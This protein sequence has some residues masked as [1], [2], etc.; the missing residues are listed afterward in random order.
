M[1]TL[2]RLSVAD[3]DRPVKLY[4]PG[5]CTGK[6]IEFSTSLLCCNW[7]PDSAWAIAFTPTQKFNPRTIFTQQSR[8]TPPHPTLKAYIG[9]FLQAGTMIPIINPYQSWSV[10]HMHDHVSIVYQM[11][12]FTCNDKE[13]RQMHKRLVF[14]KNKRKKEKK[15]TPGS[16]TEMVTW[17]SHRPAVF[18]HAT[19]LIVTHRNVCSNQTRINKPT[20]LPAPRNPP[21]HPCWKSLAKLGSCAVFENSCRAKKNRDFWKIR[22]NLVKSIKIWPNRVWRVKGTVIFQKTKIR[23]HSPIIRSFFKNCFAPLRRFE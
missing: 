20:H 9:P 15:H 5:P 8:A 2:S 7:S 6:T 21:F 12:K 11:V 14:S 10:Q 23:P 16:Q 1:R 4:C 13:V 17:F 22:K 3:L 19:I 18:N